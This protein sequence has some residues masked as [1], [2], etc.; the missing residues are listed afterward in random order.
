MI[1]IN[2]AV[3]NIVTYYNVT[4]PEY[5]I[6]AVFGEYIVSEG[7][8]PDQDT[9]SLSPM[10]LVFTGSPGRVVVEEDNVISVYERYEP[11]LPIRT[12]FTGANAMQN[13][14]LHYQRMKDCFKQFTDQKVLAN[15]PFKRTSIM[16]DQ[17]RYLLRYQAD[18][19]YLVHFDVLIDQEIIDGFDE[20]LKAYSSPNLEIL[21]T[22]REIEGLTNG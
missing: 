10:E 13:A 2:Q 5:G 8:D 19:R 21:L 3:Y 6:Q 16:F 7:E 9:V 4:H 11:M 17:T 1:D 15:I 18:T 20:E 12:V 14:G 22:T